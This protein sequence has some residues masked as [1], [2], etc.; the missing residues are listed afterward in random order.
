MILASQ[1]LVTPGIPL[2]SKPLPS[3][4]LVVAGVA[5]LGNASVASAGSSVSSIHLHHWS[6]LLLRS[7]QHGRQRHCG[8]VPGQQ[9]RVCQGLLWEE[10]EGWCDLSCL[11]QPGAGEG[12]GVLQR[13]VRHPGGWVHLWAH[14]GDTERQPNGKDAA[15]NP[16][17][18][19]FADPGR[20]LQLLWLQGS[21]WDPRAVHHPLRR[22]A[23]FTLR[24]KH[25]EPQRGD[26]FPDRHGNRRV[27]GTFQEASEY[28][29][30]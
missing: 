4:A 26:R 11:Q 20:S 1:L 13:S 18:D 12:P 14:Q 24:E 29:R 5:G 8:E 17:E 30:C 10:S 25:R 6:D 21:Q 23:Q 7:I 27:D 15:Q 19:C 22:D 28:S 3:V 16:P 2:W 9:S